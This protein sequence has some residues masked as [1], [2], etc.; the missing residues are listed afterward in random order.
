MRING[1]GFAWT[2]M[3]I[4]Y[5]HDLAVCLVLLSVGLALS[6]FLA[7]R[8]MKTVHPLIGLDTLYSILHTLFFPNI[9]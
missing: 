1:T 4:M 5:K 9:Y 6:H 7:R 2:Y 3:Y 8:D